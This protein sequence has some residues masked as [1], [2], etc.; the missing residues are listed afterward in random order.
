MQPQH[1]CKLKLF[2][3]AGFQP[4]PSF[5][6]VAVHEH[7][8]CSCNNFGGRKCNPSVHKTKERENLEYWNQ[9]KNLADYRKQKASLHIAHSL[10][11]N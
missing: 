4:L 10:K 7:S 11:N 8:D 9:A 1:K 6:F 2:L 3:I 5:D